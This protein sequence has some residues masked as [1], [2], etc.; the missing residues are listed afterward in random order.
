MARQRELFDFGTCQAQGSFV[1]H[2]LLGSRCKCSL[3]AYAPQRSMRHTTRIV[4]HICGAVPLEI[5]VWKCCGT[6]GGGGL[7]EVRGQQYDLA[8]CR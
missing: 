1:K 5:L 7:V 8:E 2:E 3:T 6:D 4:S